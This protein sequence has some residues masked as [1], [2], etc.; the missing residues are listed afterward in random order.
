MYTKYFFF[1]ANRVL[2]KDRRGKGEEYPYGNGSISCHVG[3]EMEKG[4][5]YSST[6]VFVSF[7]LSLRKGS[8]VLVVNR[9]SRFLVPNPIA[10]IYFRFFYNYRRLRVFIEWFESVLR[11]FFYIFIRLPGLN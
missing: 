2:R 7:T 10:Q 1:F 11:A 5:L 8:G 9:C 6:L 3:K 4:D